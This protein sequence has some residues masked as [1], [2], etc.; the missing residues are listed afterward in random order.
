MLPDLISLGCLVSPP[1]QKPF[2]QQHLWFSEAAVPQSLR[3]SAQLADSYTCPLSI[4]IDKGPV[5]KNADPYR[6]AI[7]R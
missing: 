2:K 3:V 6:C 1:H 7:W 5:R 4:T